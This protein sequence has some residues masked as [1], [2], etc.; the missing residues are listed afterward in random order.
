MMQESR[1]AFPCSRRH[2]P[3]RL[4]WDGDWDDEPAKLRTDIFHLLSGNVQILTTGGYTDGGDTPGPVKSPSRNVGV[5]GC[6]VSA[7]VG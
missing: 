5:H 2:T 4:A 1:F 3:S 7:N 6:L